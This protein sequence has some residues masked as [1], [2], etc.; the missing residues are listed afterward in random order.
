MKVIF[1][2]NAATTPLE[3]RVKHEMVRMMENFGNPSSIHFSGRGAKVE[4]EVVRKRI[5][6]YLEAEPGEIFLTSGGT[7]AD[8]MALFCSVRDLGVKRIIT[9]AIEHHA[10]GHPVEFMVER[11]EVEAAYLS[12]NEFGDIDLAE[13]EALLKDGP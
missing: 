12:V 1:L 6:Q 8:N 5:A 9:T 7:E 4:V 11:G 3:P 2:D 13:L 10:V